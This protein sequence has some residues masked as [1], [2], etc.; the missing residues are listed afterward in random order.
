MVHH[1]RG[2]LAKDSAL[3]PTGLFIASEIR[4]TETRNA[5]REVLLGMVTLI[6]EDW[7]R[8]MFPGHVSETVHAMF[9]PTQRRVIARRETRFIDLTLR[10]KDSDAVPES[11]AARLLAIEVE[12]GRCVI[13]HW[14]AAVDAWI[15]RVNLASEL[16]P[17]WQ[18]P[19]ITSS[20]RT[21]LIEQICL[22][23]TSYRE[24]K[25]SEV[26]PIIR[27]K[28]TRKSVPNSQENTPNTIGGKIR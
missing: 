17:E 9:D 23:A 8:E 27:A 5:D 11:E 19:S 13:K 25:Q 14:D 2:T 1:R 7:L 28:V 24:I 3:D 18:I 21:S 4:E 15:R 22:G 12:S 26:W 20:D 16:F 6:E 10:S